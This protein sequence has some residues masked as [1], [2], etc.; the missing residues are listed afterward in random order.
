MENWG[1]GWM[2]TCFIVILPVQEQEGPTDYLLNHYRHPI[3]ITV[4]TPDFLR[5]YIWTI[6]I[7]WFSLG[8][9]KNGS[10][11]YNRIQRGMMGRSHSGTP[12]VC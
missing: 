9:Q 1:S 3:T 6:P 12:P 5:S 11:M 2:N 4:M 7:K 10:I 8:S